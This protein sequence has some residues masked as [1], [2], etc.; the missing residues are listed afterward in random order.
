M[1]LRRVAKWP[2]CRKCNSDLT[3]RSETTRR[4]DGTTVDVYR[5]RCG[6]LRRVPRG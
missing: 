1:S 4:K 5:C 6:S 2:T 3:T